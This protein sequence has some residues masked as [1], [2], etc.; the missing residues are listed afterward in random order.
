MPTID[1]NGRTIWIDR[2]DG[3]RFVVRAD[4]KLTAFIEL[5]SAI[6]RGTPSVKK[7]AAES[8]CLSPGRYSPLRSK[9]I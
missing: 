2:D 6:F 8:R 1:S 5:E 4:E 9:T 7:P 3:K